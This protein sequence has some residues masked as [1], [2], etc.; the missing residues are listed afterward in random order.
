MIIDT[1]LNMFQSLVLSIIDLVPT[2]PNLPSWISSSVG[3]I[4]KGL[5]FF[6]NDMWSTIIINISAWIAIQYTWAIIEWVYK[7]IP[8]IN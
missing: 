8:G 7:K 3:L 4:Q 5:I 6:P 1:I 2:M